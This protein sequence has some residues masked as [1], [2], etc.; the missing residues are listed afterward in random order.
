MQKKSN[1]PIIQLWDFNFKED[2]IRLLL[3]ALSDIGIHGY[4]NLHPK[5]F[6]SGDKILLVTQK[7][8]GMG[9][10]VRMCDE[11]PYYKLANNIY[12]ITYKD[13]EE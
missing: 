9:I 1:R 8:E 6:S 11:Y 3:F 7:L 12:G 4:A 13:I 5:Y 2:E 10:L